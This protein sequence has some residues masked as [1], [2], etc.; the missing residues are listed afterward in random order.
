[1]KDFVH[2]FITIFRRSNGCRPSMVTEMHNS[3]EAL[4]E[5]GH[6]KDNNDDD[7]YGELDANEECDDG[8]S[9]SAL[10]SDENGLSNPMNSRLVRGNWMP[11]E[12]E[13]LREGDTSCC[14][15]LVRAYFSF[16]IAV[17]QHGAKCWKKISFII[18]GRSAIQCMQRWTGCLK[19]GLVKGSWTTEVLTTTHLCS[20]PTTVHAHKLYV[21]SNRRT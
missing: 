14:T 13:R 15:F 9:T 4:E 21:H 6:Q 1:M 18:S 10:Y 12:D 16:M 3:I 11:D 20:P 19:P 8:V 5:D 7:D 2:Y 17:R